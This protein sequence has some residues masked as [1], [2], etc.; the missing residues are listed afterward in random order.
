M[1]KEKL[2][3]V[4]ARYDYLFDGPYIMFD[5]HIILSHQQFE[6]IDDSVEKYT[7]EN[8]LLI[9]EEFGLKQPKSHFLIAVNDKSFPTLNT[10]EI[11][12]VFR[13]ELGVK[14]II[15]LLNDESL[16]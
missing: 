1:L 13:H 8:H 6:L 12:D 3:V 14:N 9:A 7:Q 16:I 15:V 10:S 11:A 4:R 5:P 2:D